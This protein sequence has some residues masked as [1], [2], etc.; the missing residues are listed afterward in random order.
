M[1][2]VLIVRA[3]HVSSQGKR[4]LFAGCEECDIPFSTKKDLKVNY[5]LK[6]NKIKFKTIF[7]HFLI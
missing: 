6:F 4:K 7:P 3:T 5:L 2:E 1:D